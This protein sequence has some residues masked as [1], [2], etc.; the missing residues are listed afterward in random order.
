LNIQDIL[1][2]VVT[3]A[4]QLWSRLCCWSVLLVVPA[5]IHLLTQKQ[6]VWAVLM[7]ISLTSWYMYSWAISTFYSIPF[8]RI[9]VSIA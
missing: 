6:V 4:A 2:S 5:P 7:A 3:A 8:W 9:Y 1:F